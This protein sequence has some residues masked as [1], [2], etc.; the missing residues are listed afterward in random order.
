MN[1]A[2]TLSQDTE[3]PEGSRELNKLMPELLTFLQME[4]F[5][6]RTHHGYTPGHMHL[7]LGDGTTLCGK[8][9]DEGDTLFNG[10]EYKLCDKCVRKQFRDA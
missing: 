3:L 6:V 2:F 1:T 7:G 9:G 10:V 4:G 8:T 5:I